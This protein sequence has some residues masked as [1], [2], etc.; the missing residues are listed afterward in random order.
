MRRFVGGR[1]VD[2]IGFLDEAGAHAEYED[3]VVA[4]DAGDYQRAAEVL[5]DIYIRAEN[6]SGA[7]QQALYH[8]LAFCYAHLADGPT[9]AS[10]A[11]AYIGAVGS[12]QADPKLLRLFYHGTINDFS[13]MF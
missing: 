4:Y 6:L 11:A 10:Y 1:D 12:A 13:G 5:G 7:Q 2:L 9:C 8:D 3:A